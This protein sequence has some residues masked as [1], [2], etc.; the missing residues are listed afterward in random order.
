MRESLGRVTV[1]TQP[2]DDHENRRLPTREELL[3]RGRPFPPYEEIRIEG[4][5]DEEEEVF[6]RAIA[7]A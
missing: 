7:E 5:S 1:S 3:S 2:A 4:L 6:L